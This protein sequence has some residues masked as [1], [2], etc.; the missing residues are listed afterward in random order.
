MSDT[1]VP[2]S[3]SSELKKR[4]LSGIVMAVLAITSVVVGGWFFA[5]FWGFAAVIVAFEWQRLVHGKAEF[6]PVSLACAAAVSATLAGLTDNLLFWLLVPILTAIT[7]ILGPSGQRQWAAIGVV[8]AAGLGAATM[9][10]R[11]NGYDGI[12][13]LFWLFGVVWGTDTLAYFT[14]RALGGP[15]LWPRVSP[16]KTWSG[17]IGGLVGGVIIA[18]I[19]LSLCG[20]ALMWQHVLI[21]VALSILTQLGDLFESSIKRRYGAKDAGTILPGHGGVMDRL[22]GFIFAVIFEAIV[23]A[24]HSGLQNVPGGL[25]YWP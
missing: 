12:V 21:S 10:C 13:V 2:A 16:K 14:G 19:I 3:Q 23:G 7:G 5:I 24:A 4:I 6:L 8:Y 25:L 20:I 22:D 17:A 11:G 18:C 1:L 15:K 9:L